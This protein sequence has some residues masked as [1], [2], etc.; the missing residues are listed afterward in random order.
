MV[1]N[2]NFAIASVIIII[3]VISVHSLFYQTTTQ[4][5]KLY[6]ILSWLALLSTVLD[7][8]TGKTITHASN[9]PLGLNYFLHT[10]Y[11]TS[12]VSISYLSAAYIYECI[13]WKAKFSTYLNTIYVALFI[14]LT[15]INP[16]TGVVYSF[17]DG[18]YVHGPLFIFNYIICFLFIIQATVILS[19]N[20]KK[21]KRRRI[22]VLHIAFVVL[23]VVGAFIQ[24]FNPTLL[25][26]DFTISVSLLLMMFTLETTDYQSLQ[27]VLEDLKK[28]Q[29][30]EQKAKQEAISANKAKTNFLTKMSHEI[31]TPINTV[32]GLNDMILRESTD[33]QIV[34]YAG[35]IKNASKSLL[36]AINDILDLAKIESGKMTL[37]IEEYSL[38]DLIESITSMI[39]IRAESKGLNFILKVDEKLP[40]YL[41]GDEARVKQIILNLLTNAVKYTQTG[42]VEF[43]VGGN[44]RKETVMLHVEVKDTGVGIKKENLDKLFGVFERIEDTQNKGIEGSGLGISIVQQLLGLMDSSLKVKSVYGQGSTFSFDLRQRYKNHEAIGNINN[45][46]SEAVRE[47]DYQ[48]SFIAPDAHI[49]IVDD[50]DINLYVVKNLLKETEIQITT[51]TSG[52]ECLELVKNNHYDLIFLDHMMPGMDGIETLHHIKNEENLCQNTPVVAL[53]ANA[54]AGIEDVYQK[55]GFEGYIPKPIDQKKIEEVISTLLPKVFIKDA[56][57]RKR[58]QAKVEINIPEIE[59]MDSAYAM[60]HFYSAD[61]FVDVLQNFYITLAQNTEYIE[62]LVQDLD[63]EQAE[64]GSTIKSYQIAVHTMKSSSAL[65]GM[66]QIAGLSKVAEDAAR[67]EDINKIKLLTPLLTNE[68]YKM[69]AR[70]Q[71]IFVKDETKALIECNILKAYLSQ[72]EKAFHKLDIDKMDSIILSL[73]NYSYP[74]EIKELIDKLKISVSGLDEKEGIKHINGI[75]NVLEKQ[76]KGA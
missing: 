71:E 19:I 76:I 24:V 16:I 39:K 67:A 9:V 58:R 68:L 38:A 56:P 12:T 65:V 26:T 74:D 35:K 41:Y 28:S 5:N 44:I 4:A 15:V 54:V 63:N 27:K 17:V 72:L 43:I 22:L 59:G 50:T 18:E 37:L 2:Y 48:V 53:T 21:Y 14:V 34:E 33:Q 42:Q 49:L 8:I 7:I 32:M 25:L 57:V 64:I 73:D 45:H 40:L 3:S 47:Y 55:E 10:L 6:T 52:A 36:E 61:V 30:A 70:L 51:A 62:Q 1:Y 11:H 23:N 66:A 31:R 60:S 75:K 13:D 29:K 20:R 69:Q 46:I